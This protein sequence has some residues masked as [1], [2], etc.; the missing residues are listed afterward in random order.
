[1]NEMLPPDTKNKEREFAKLKGSSTE[2]VGI[3]ERQTW[4]LRPLT[5]L[6]ATTIIG[7]LVYIE[8]KILDHILYSYSGAK[9]TVYFLAISPILA[10]TLIVIFLLIGVFRGFNGNDLK[11][12]P[13]NL[14]LSSTTGNSM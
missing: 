6:F 1:M 4:W 8:C 13:V 11:R 10:I 14:L 3:L 5:M 12:L 7:W 2:D 9:D